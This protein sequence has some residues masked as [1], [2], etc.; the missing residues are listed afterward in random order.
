MRIEFVKCH[1]KDALGYT[2]LNDI[3][4]TLR[5]GSLNIISGDDKSGRDYLLYLVFGIVK[6]SEGSIFVDERFL[7]KFNYKELKAHQENILF[8]AKNPKLL[9]RLNVFQNIALPLKIRG[10]QKSEINKRVGEA[11]KLLEIRHLEF[12][13]P[14]NLSAGILQKICLARCVALKPKAILANDLFFHLNP[15]ERDAT[16]EVLLTL[17]EGGTT[18]VIATDI[19]RIFRIENARYITLWRGELSS[20]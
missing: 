3:N 8:L 10:L 1:A 4:L 11:L 20:A 6:C 15:K 5:S 2:T 7:T 19:T 14:R 12:A 9:K 18:I 16:S 13:S 17:S